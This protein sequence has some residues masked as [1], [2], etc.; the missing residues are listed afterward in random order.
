M[1]GKVEHKKVLRIYI[2][3]TDSYNGQ[4]LW[5]YILKSANEN[6]LAGATVYKA[7][8]GVGSH[9]TIHTFDIFNLSAKMPIVIEIIEQED[10]ISNFLNSLESALK[11]AFVTIHSV[12]TI[13]YK[14]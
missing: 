8:A 4:A 2:D 5:K 13:T 14:V 10:K 9:N 7:V 11:E 6:N 3:N 1:R 12:D